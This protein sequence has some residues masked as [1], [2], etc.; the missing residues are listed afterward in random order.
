MRADILS[1]SWINIQSF[2]L[3]YDAGCEMLVRAL[4]Q[5]VLSL[6]WYNS[7]QTF[8]LGLFDIDFIYWRDK[9]YLLSVLAMYLLRNLSISF[10]LMNLLTKLVH[11]ISLVYLKILWHLSPF[12]SF[13]ILVICVCFSCTVFLGNSHVNLSKNEFLTLISFIMSTFSISLISTFTFI[14]SFF[15][16]LWF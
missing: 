10:I 13:L 14:V 16:N 2:T 4:Y 12:I 5:T 8:Y 6:I 3:I 15:S 7:F 9:L 11:I 1:C